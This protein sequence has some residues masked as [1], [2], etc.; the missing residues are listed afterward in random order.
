MTWSLIALDP[1]TGELGI[2]VATRFFAAGAR[3]PFVLSG[4]GAIATQ[5]LVNPY[6]GIDG[7]QLL[8]N[9]NTPADALNILLE[10]DPGREH[11]QVHLIGYSGDI[12]AH[13][14]SACLNWAGHRRP[15]LFSCW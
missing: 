1:A 15:L 6:Y 4:V 7:L 12:A 8:R 2:A 13:T 11:R 5:A 3:V 14:G 10:A 9:G